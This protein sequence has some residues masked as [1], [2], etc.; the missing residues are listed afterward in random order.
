[1]YDYL[2]DSKDWCAKPPGQWEM[3]LEAYLFIIGMLLDIKTLL[4]ILPMQSLI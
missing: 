4:P 3:T 1:M 2:N